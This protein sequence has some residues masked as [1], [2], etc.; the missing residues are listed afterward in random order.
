MISHIFVR[1]RM[2]PFAI[3]QN[4]ISHRFD[5]RHGPS[6]DLFSVLSRVCVDTAELFLFSAWFNRSWL[7][8]LRTAPL[9]LKPFYGAHTLKGFNEVCICK[10]WGYNE[11]RGYCKDNTGMRSLKPTS[12]NVATRTEESV[13]IYYKATTLETTTRE[14]AHKYEPAMWLLRLLRSHCETPSRSDCECNMRLL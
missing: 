13:W 11:A 12:G 4:I 6:Y 2:I 14:L 9:L 10:L 5:R 1:E 7:C 3:L 8:T